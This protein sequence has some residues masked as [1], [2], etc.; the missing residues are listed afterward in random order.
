MWIRVSSQ[1][2]HTFEANCKL[3]IPNSKA[4]QSL[5]ATKEVKEGRRPWRAGRQAVDGK[6]SHIALPHTCRALKS[7]NPWDTNPQI[8]YKYLRHHRNRGTGYICWATKAGR[9]PIIRSTDP[10]GVHFPPTACRTIHG[11]INP[12]QIQQSKQNPDKST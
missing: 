5:K 1:I 3:K 11:K 12:T 4:T 8:L 2:S 9:R 7:T 10:D 6:H